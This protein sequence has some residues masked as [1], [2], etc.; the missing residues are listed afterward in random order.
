[1]PKLKTRKSAAKRY[2]ISAKGKIRRRKGGISHLREHKSAKSKTA[3]KGMIQV[4]DTDAIKIKF[5]LP[6][7]NK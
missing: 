3:N 2:K 5:M 4:H 6:Y 1:M 7:M